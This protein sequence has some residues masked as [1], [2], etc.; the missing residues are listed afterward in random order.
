MLLTFIEAGTGN[1]ISINPKHVV[2]VFTQTIEDVGTKTVIN[3]LNGNLA[4]EDDY[5]D[6]VGRIQGELK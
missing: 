3:M 6:V 4:V 2:C 1:T 5:L